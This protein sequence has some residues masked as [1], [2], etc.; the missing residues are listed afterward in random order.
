MLLSV[1]ISKN[2]DGKT[3][4]WRVGARDHTASSIAIVARSSARMVHQD[5]HNGPASAYLGRR[6]ERRCF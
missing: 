3:L 6:K 5:H 4:K 1:L 2:N